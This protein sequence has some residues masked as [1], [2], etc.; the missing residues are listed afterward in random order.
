MPSLVVNLRDER[1]IWTVP[2]WAIDEIRSAAPDRLEVVVV[3]S[4]VD[5]LGDGGAAAPEAI[6]A[7]PG[8][9]IYL[10]FG[11][12]EP[13]F[14]AAAQS[15]GSLR[16]VHSATTGIG[17][18]LY[19]AMRASPVILTNSAG[20]HAEPMA[21]TIVGMMHYFARGLDFAVRAQQA[22]QWDRS[23]FDAADS[24]VHEVAG[25]TVGLL[26][27]GGIGKAVAERAMA[28]GMKVLAYRRRPDPKATGV[29]QLSGSGGL[30]RVLG[31]SD[32]LVVSLPLTPE[33]KGLLHRERI[34]LLRKE[35][36][37]INVGRGELLDETALTE[38]LAAGHLRG[39]GLDVFAEEP[40]PPDSPLWRLPNVLITP[41]VSP[42]T[43][44]FWR[45]EVDLI[46]E[47]LERY[48]AGET[49][50]NTVDK[51]AGY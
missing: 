10:G 48:E 11:L 8:A 40:L 16:W 21:D 23:P 7:I 37:V 46:L 2:D 27:Y 25:R 20:T 43:H 31:E 34:A 35:A 22:R 15:G 5:G 32:Y 14:R 45:R 28:L 51:T 36:V 18:S 44:R 12:P 9:E 39:A 38:A 29:Q 6:A 3:D 33:T 49:L 47:N 19:P 13:L 24:P 17:G 42:T 1:P 26:G 30:Q 50:L 41:H 4:P